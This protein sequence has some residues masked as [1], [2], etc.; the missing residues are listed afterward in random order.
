MVGREEKRLVTRSR[1]GTLNIVARTSSNKLCGTLE[2]TRLF[3]DV[4]LR[5]Y[6]ITSLGNTQDGFCYISD[7]AVT[8]AYRRRGVG[9]ALLKAALM[10][11][12]SGVAMTPVPCVD[13]ANNFIGVNGTVLYLH[14]EAS[15][16]AA[17]QL[18]RG[19]GFA[20]VPETMHTQQLAKE[21]KLAGT[22]GATNAQILMA[23]RLEN[24]P[25]YV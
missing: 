25:P 15:N 16:V 19:A 17:E 1:S 7:M 2:L 22:L 23:R 8:R 24:P 18:Y 20:P 21:L 13:A 6:E 9:R 12:S 11:S 10:F 3:W 4:R 5:R 14:V